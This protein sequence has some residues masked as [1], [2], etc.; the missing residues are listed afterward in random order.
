MTKNQD[1][2][3]HSDHVE[4][5]EY[6]EDTQRLTWYMTDSLIHISKVFIIKQQTNERPLSSII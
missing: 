4:L 6:Y 2:I 3:V 1:S 5:V